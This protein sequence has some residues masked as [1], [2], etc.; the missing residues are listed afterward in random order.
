M[1]VKY[2]TFNDFQENTYVLYDDTKEC[3]IIDPGCNTEAERQEL[4]D[5]IESAGLKPVKLVN[6][7][8]HI[9]HVLGND[10]VARKY[11]LSLEAHEGESVVLSNMQSVA[12]MYGIPYTP[13][14]PI[15]VHLDESKVLKFGNTELQILF[16][17]GHSPA[18]ISFFHAS[19]EQLIAGD[20]LFRG[21]IGRTDLPG[22]DFDTLIASIKDKFYSL[23]DDV[24]VYCGH[25]PTTTIGM[26]R[27][28]NPFL[29]E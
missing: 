21:S 28:T 1:Q 17:P 14:P 5:Y 25:G 12:N 8:C 24:H 7:H 11:H 3:V 23:G 6:T 4:V 27:R 19:S 20:V 22:G 9:D 29:I 15:E 2:F 16:T 18:S 10:F 13:S 26:E